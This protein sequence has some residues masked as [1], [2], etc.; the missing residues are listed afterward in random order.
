[1][2]KI[3]P[4]IIAVIIVGAVSFY[5]GMLYRKSKGSANN[6]PETG[7]VMFR[8]NTDRGNFQGGPGNGRNTAN[9]TAGEII[10]KDDSSITVKLFDGGSKIIFFSAST[11]ITKTA[12]GDANDLEVGKT[13]MASGTANSDGSITATTIQLRPGMQ[14]PQ[15]AGQ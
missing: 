6:F 8:G 3:L 10:A 12:D 2:K 4:I 13:V 5:G 1:M 7:N 9:A 14:V 11:D 15:E